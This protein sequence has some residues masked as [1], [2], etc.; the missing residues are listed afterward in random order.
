MEEKMTV[1]LLPARKQAGFA[2]RDEENP[3]LRVAAY[4][5]VSTDSDEQE[6]S[7]E[8]QITHYTAYINSHPDWELAGIYADDGISGTNTKK[9]E[10]FNR[11]ID[12][13]MAG[14]IDKVIT[15]S[16]SRF[17][18]NTV[19]CLNYIRKLKDKNIPVYFEKKDFDTANLSQKSEI[20]QNTPRYAE[21]KGS[22][23]RYF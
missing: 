11:M 22:I 23:K 6:T 10:E 2:K 15:K 21:I 9:R 16:I 14:K 19:D 3:K 4:C 17:A 7:Y 13:C 18:R 5:R 20:M 1:T 12:D 8:A